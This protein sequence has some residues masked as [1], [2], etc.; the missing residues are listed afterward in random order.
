MAELCILGISQ[1]ATASESKG[2]GTPE[3]LVEIAEQAEVDAPARVSSSTE[4]P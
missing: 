2:A 3:E 4:A 1:T